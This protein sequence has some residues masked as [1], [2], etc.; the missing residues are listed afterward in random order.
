[1][2]RKLVRAVINKYINLRQ[3]LEKD[4]FMQ[5]MIRNIHYQNISYIIEVI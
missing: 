5:F 3:M 1:M 2:E 4:G